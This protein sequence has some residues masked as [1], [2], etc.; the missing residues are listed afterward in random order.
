MAARETICSS[1]WKS[2]DYGHALASGWTVVTA[3]HREFSRIDGLKV[4]DW[5]AE[6]D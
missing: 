1:P 3:N 2:F 6:G 5:T 4:V